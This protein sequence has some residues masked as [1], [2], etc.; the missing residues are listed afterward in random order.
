[1]L[2]YS[3][4]SSLLPHPVLL[5]S[6]DSWQIR[7]LFYSSLLLPCPGSVAPLTEYRLCSGL[8]CSKP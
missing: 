7:M 5:A 4:L 2:F 3:S 1:M 6:L 8:A